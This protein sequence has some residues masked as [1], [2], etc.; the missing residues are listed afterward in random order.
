MIQFKTYPSFS[1]PV[2]LLASA[3]V[4]TACKKYLPEDRETIGIDSDFT[5]TLYQPVLGRTTL[6]SNNFYQGSTSFP[7]DFKMVN[8]RRMNGDAAPELEDVFPVKVWKEAYTGTETSMAEIEKK[9]QT[10]Y[11]KLFEIFPHSGQF[12]MWAEAASNFIRSQPDSGYLFDVE[13]SNSGG[14]RYFRDLRLRPMKERP[15][16]PSNL[17]PATGQSLSTGI[18]PSRISIKGQSRERYLST[19]DVRVFIRKRT[20]DG[21]PA[22]TLRFMFL[23]TLYNPID[24]AKFSGTDWGNLVHGFNPKMTATDVTYEVAYPIPLAAIRTRYTTPGF[25]ERAAVTFTYPRLG[26]GGFRDDGMIGL[27]FAI[28]EPGDWEIVFAFINDNPKFD[29]D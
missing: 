18:F 20:G 16:E 6:F 27:D 21:T 28:Y 2:L 7:A 10:Q 15:Y 9:R 19:G 29:N 25:P 8:P 17:D 23:D 24:P 3:L 11:R 13:L 26:F 12:T 5:Q 22:N 4:L 14:R 1:F